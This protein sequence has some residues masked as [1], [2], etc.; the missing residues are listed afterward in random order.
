[1]GT[2]DDTGL[3]PDGGS[4]LVFDFPYGGTTVNAS[5]YIDA[6]NTNLFYT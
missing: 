3:S 4:S 6:A 5:T 1:M 2:N